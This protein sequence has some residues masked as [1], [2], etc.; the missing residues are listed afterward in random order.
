MNANNS[1]TQ[2]RSHWTHTIAGAIR[3]AF[4]M[5]WGIDAFLKWQPAFFDNYSTYITGIISG[6]PAWLLP[7]F[8]FWGN[9][10]QMNP[11]LF[12]WLTRII[13]TLIAAGLLLGLFRKWVYLLGGIFALLIWSIPEGFGGPYTPGATDVGAGLIYVFVFIALI[14]IDYTMGKAPYSLDF[15]IERA[16]PSWRYAAEWAPAATLQ[17]EPPY[18]PW[19]YQIVTIIGLIVMLVI[20]LYILGS[21]LSSAPPATGLVVGW[22]YDLVHSGLMTG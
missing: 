16:Y 19:R 8:N 1:K 20:F 9:L 15:Y 2:P 14:L 5:A 17:E 21:E 6:Q 12:A 22:C 13:E 4:G 11:D 3:V 10:I 7:W 18:L